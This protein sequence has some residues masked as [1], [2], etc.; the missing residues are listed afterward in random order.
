VHQGSLDRKEDFLVMS[1]L[2]VRGHVIPDVP[3]K[4]YL[5]PAPPGKPELSFHPS[6]DQFRA[7]STWHEGGFEA[8]VPGMTGGVQADLKSDCVYFEDMAT[9][10]WGRDVSES[11]MRGLP[12]NLRVTRNLR[13][14][15]RGRSDIVFWITPNGYLSPAMTIMDSYTGEVECKRVYRRKFD[16]GITQVEFD[17]HFFKL[18]SSGDEILRTS[19]LV[20][21][22]T[23]P[24]EAKDVETVYDTLIPVLDDFLLIASL[25]CRT[26]TSCVG[27]QASDGESCTEFYRGFIWYPDGVQVR[28]LGRGL[29]S[30]TDCESFISR[31][32]QAFQTSTS[33][34]ELRGG[35]Y[36]VL[37]NKGQT[38]ESAFLSTYAAM[39]DL[40]LRFRKANQLEFVFVDSDWSLIK[41][42]LRSW[43]KSGAPIDIPKE[44]RRHV[45]A[46]LEE[47]N[48]IPARWAFD[49]MCRRIGVD[50]SDLWPTFDNGPKTTLSTIRNRL[51][52]GGFPERAFTGLGTA[53]QHLQWTVERLLLALLGWPVD[54][55][56]V[57]PAFLRRQ[58]AAM[59]SLSQ[60]RDELTRLLHAAP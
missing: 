9:K 36:A 15:S 28:T 23:Y 10:F 59:A 49:E 26:R 58:A 47:L 14:E 16:L 20:G 39:E 1:S 13:G 12:Q 4:V 33:Q 11:K 48:R 6:H 60:D 2:N 5:P 35:I 46:K 41:T 44:K 57:S 45:Y 3:C 37:G 34:A 54:R 55:S 7:I 56:E 30:M 43:V 31:A 53:L 38:A 19:C 51:I 32:F 42:E 17:R 27:W 40:L 24:G 25:S 52:H 18:P 21:T 22:A 29:V 8:T 50:L